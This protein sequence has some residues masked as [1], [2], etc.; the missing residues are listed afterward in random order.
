[1]V[2]ILP[3][4]LA[5]LAGGLSLWAGSFQV[6]PVRVELSARRLYA[7]IAV[8]NSGNETETIQVQALRW[9][10]KGAGEAYAETDDILLNPPIFTLAPKQTQHMRLGL[11]EPKVGPMEVCYRLILE[12]LPPSSK[13]APNQIRT[14]LRISI[15]VYVPP[16]QR[17]VP[18]LAWRL[19][20]AESGKR[21]LRVENVG[22]AHVLITR[23]GLAVHDQGEPDR[24]ESINICVLPGGSHEWTISDE[25]LLR[26]PAIL[27]R[28]LTD[29]GEIRVVVRQGNP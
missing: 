22:T 28:T 11:R 10:A 1:M 29:K 13:P 4:I 12:E 2:R 23:M 8:T 16:A 3:T 18:Q 24:L 5:W 9:S 6:N 14:L 17:A 7:S 27:V 15:P 20:P 19:A 21:K 26:S 25:R